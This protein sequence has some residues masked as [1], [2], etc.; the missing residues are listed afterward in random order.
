MLKVQEALSLEDVQQAACQ[1]H[2]RAANTSPYAINTGRHKNWYGVIRFDSDSPNR[3]NSV[4]WVYPDLPTFER[5]LDRYRKGRA[6]GQPTNWVR[7]NVT[8]RW[9]RKHKHGCPH[10]GESRRNI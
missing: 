8:V 6:Q 9:H 2:W 10:S 4:Q 1:Q 3:S 5:D 7:F